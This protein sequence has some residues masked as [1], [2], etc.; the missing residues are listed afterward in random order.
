MLRTVEFITVGK[1]LKPFGVKGQ[2]RVQSLTDVPGRLEELAQ[3]TLELRT[4]EHV[5]TGVTSVGLNGRSYLMGFS[6]C[7]TPEEAGRF[8]GAWLKIPQQAV[9]PLPGA[10]YYQFQLIGLTVQEETGKVLG[11][12]EEVLTLPGQH[13]FVVRGPSGEVLIPATQNMVRSV[14]L[15]EHVMTVSSLD[16]LSNVEEGGAPHDA[17]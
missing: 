12:L 13:L 3:V 6:V 17:M 10:C 1:V 2:L 4:G 16:G 5:E 8:R 11:V 7:S 15:L 14:D 9:P